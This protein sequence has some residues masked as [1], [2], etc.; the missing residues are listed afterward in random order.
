LTA[1]RPT[2]RD[3][4][5][6]LKAAKQAG[7]S[8]KRVEIRKDAVVLIPGEP[9]TGPEPETEDAEI[10]RYRKEAHDADI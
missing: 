7:L 6:A 10:L 4:A 9:E 5:A 3:I 8:V 1:D 2:F